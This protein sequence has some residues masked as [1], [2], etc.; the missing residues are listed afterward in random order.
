MVLQPAPDLPDS[1]YAGGKTVL[2]WFERKGCPGL[3]HIV[4]ESH[5]EFASLLDR[6]ALRELGSKAACTGCDASVVSH[7]C[8]KGIAEHPWVRSSRG[9]ERAICQFDRVRLLYYVYSA[10]AYGQMIL[11]RT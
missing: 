3:L 1:R 11:I 10:W 6:C 8:P 7:P 5:Q 2:I 9:D 4:L